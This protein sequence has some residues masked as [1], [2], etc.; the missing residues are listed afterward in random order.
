[1][2]R[3][4]AEAGQPATALACPSAPPDWEGAR[5]F[6]VVTGTVDRPQVRY[7]E[8]RELTQELLDL[9]APAHPTEVFRFTAPCREGACRFFRD[10]CCGV[11]KAATSTLEAGDGEPLP[12]C[13]IRPD[14]RW[15]HEQGPAACR[16][17]AL[18][19]TE[20]PA[21]PEDFA[22]ALAGAAGGS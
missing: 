18:V 1:M 2:A 3:R 4:L 5:V 14:C 8:P 21:R 11:G 17:C 10:G 13:G 7:F 19:V 12:R 9:A 16:R 20:D 6:G 22:R 15:W